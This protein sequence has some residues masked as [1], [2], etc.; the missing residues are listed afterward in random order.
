MSLPPCGV[1]CAVRSVPFGFSINYRSKKKYRQYAA[2]V[3]GFRALRE[4]KKTTDDT[5]GALGLLYGP[6][7]GAYFRTLH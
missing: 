1:V 6:P 7:T 5:R 4:L 2:K 3:R